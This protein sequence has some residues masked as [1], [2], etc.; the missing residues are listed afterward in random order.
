M[1]CP[2]CD[3]DM[4]LQKG[5]FGAFWS[6]PYCHI[7]RNYDGTAPNW[8]RMVH[9]RIQDYADICQTYIGRLRN[10][11]SISLNNH[12]SRQFITKC[13][14]DFQG[15]TN[16]ITRDLKK[17]LE[18]PA[19]AEEVKL[20]NAAA[21][22][23]YWELSKACLRADDINTAYDFIV[24]ALRITP[25]TNEHYQ[26]MFATQTQILQFKESLGGTSASTPALNAPSTAQQ[27]E[28]PSA[29]MLEPPRTQESND[30]SSHTA[31]IIFIIIMIIVAIFLFLLN[32][33][34]D[35]QTSSPP[36][37]ISSAQQVASNV[38][39]AESIE[40]EKQSPASVSESTQQ[41]PS[42]EK[43]YH[44]KGPNGE[45]IKGHIGKN[46]RI[47][48]IPGSTYYDRTKKVSEWFFTEEEA[49][50]AG[51]RPPEK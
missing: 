8:P 30:E 21:G 47:Y 33:T 32:R 43:K 37:P 40:E 15:D 50:A 11:M 18:K 44:G 17:F 38:Q 2:I 7:T 10:D 39:Q 23:V 19:Y 34:P 24:I 48:H 6:C 25:S 45:G 1:K 26:A 5:R 20:L 27:K 14:Y 35:K 31:Q 46:G 36:P 51:Y 41:N 29:P 9:E 22:H 28:A 3:N 4:S 42:N 13:A 12:Q 49:Q 16:N